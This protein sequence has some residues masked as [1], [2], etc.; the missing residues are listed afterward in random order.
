MIG[1]PAPSGPTGSRPY[2]AVWAMMVGFF[3][4]VVDSTI[5]TVAN[6]VIKQDFGVTYHAVIWVTSAYFLAFAALLL[7]GG[8]LGDRFGPKNL[9]L[10]GLALFTASSL[11][12]G[13]SGSIDTLIAARVAQGIG[14]ALLT[15]QTFSVV[16]RTF[17]PQRRG[18]AMSLWGATAAIGMFVG[19]VAGGVLVDGLGWRWIFLINVPVGVVGLILA[20][21]LV[22]ALPVRRHRLDMLG[23]LLSGAGIFLIVFGLQEGQH[24]EWSLQ[25]WGAIAAGLGLVVAFVC[26]QSIQRLDP[27]IPLTLFR[28]RDFGLSNAGIALTSFAVVAF[29]VP[30]MFYLQEVCGLSAT[31]SA[32]VITPMAVAT[33][34]LAPV[35][36]RLVDRV[37]PRA[38]IAPGFAMMTI[39]LVWLSLEMDPETPVWRLVL[40]LTM[41]GAAGAFTW[42]PLAVTASRTLPLDLAGAGSAVYNTIRQIGAVLSSASIAALMTALLGDE[43]SHATEHR[44]DPVTEPFAEAMAQSMLLAAVAA[45]L[46]TIVA[47]FFVGRP[48]TDGREVMSKDSSTWMVGVAI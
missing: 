27:L 23:A 46:G 36:G 2:R 38:I 29:T 47:L 35:V 5:V 32:L 40:P 42:E 30:L 31:R 1:V 14:A 16:T 33:G 19:P 9:Y 43:H 6:P 8:R 34:V 18:V 44:S 11:W 3:L 41:I 7:L 48:E 17:P 28:H 24:H 12:C 26:W 22:P 15:P 4:I 21:R 13:L 37:H 25:I 45:A 10:A 39:A 20:L